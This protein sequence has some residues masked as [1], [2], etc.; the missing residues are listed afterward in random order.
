M[1]TIMVVFDCSSLT[2]I[3]YW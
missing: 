2:S 1:Q 3:G